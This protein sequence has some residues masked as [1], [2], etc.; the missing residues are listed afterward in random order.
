MQTVFIIS[1]CNNQLL[2]WIENELIWMLSFIPG[3]ASALP[4]IVAKLHAMKE[5]YM[6]A[7]LPVTSNV[8][9]KSWDLSFASVWNTIV[10]LMLLNFFVKIVNST[11]QRYLK[12]QQEK[13]MTALKKKLEQSEDNQ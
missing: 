3:V 7:P 12:K 5:K 13:E 1:V 11:A 8:K 4:N 10:W 2:D 6:A 9:V